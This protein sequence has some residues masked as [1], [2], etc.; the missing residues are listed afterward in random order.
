MSTGRKRLGILLLRK[1]ERLK[2]TYYPFN[3]FKNLM[4]MDPLIL[5][6]KIKWIT[7]QRILLR[8]Q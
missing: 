7:Q 3:R 6:K 5:L 1:K 4:L 8:L 2:E